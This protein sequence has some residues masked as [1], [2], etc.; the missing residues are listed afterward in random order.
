[1]VTGSHVAS[2]VSGVTEEDCAQ[3]WNAVPEWHVIT[4]QKVTHEIV[5]I[6]IEVDRGKEG[7]LNTS[8]FCYSALRQV[9][10]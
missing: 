9:M 5:T 3:G 8:Q 4:S 7:L 2:V 6:T 10:K 1:M